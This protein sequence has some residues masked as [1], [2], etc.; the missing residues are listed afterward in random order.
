[1]TETIQRSFTAGEIS[2]ALGAR[3][4]LNKYQTGLDTL[5][6]AFVHAEGGV[7]NRAG[8]HYS[9]Y[10]P[11]NAAD[12]KLIPFQFNTEQTYM[13]VFVD[14]KMMVIMD[15]GFVLN[16]GQAIVSITTATECVVEITGHGYSNGDEVYF[17][18][19]T[20]AGDLN[21]NRYIVSDATAN[22]FKIKWPQDS[23]YVNS[24]LFGG[25]VSGGTGA[26]L[27]TLDHTYT[28][29]QLEFV[30]FTQSADVMT[31]VHPDHDPAELSRLDHNNWTLTDV[32]YSTQQVA[33]A[34]LTSVTL[35]GSDPATDTKVYAYAVTAVSEGGQESL[36]SPTS[37]T[38]DALVLGVARGYR[39]V[40][41]AT[42]GA[43]S[44]NIYK[45]ESESSD[46]FGYIG[47]TKPASVGL[48]A[49]FEDYNIAPDISDGPPIEKLPFDGADNK[50]STVN[51]YQQRIIFGSSNN[52]PEEVYMSRIG[53]YHSMRVAI[54]VKA[55]DAIQFTIAS[56]QVNEIR[57]IV[58]VGALLVLTS[59][60]EYKISEGQ[61]QVLAPTTVSA[62]PQSYYGSSHVQP[63]VV[64]HTALFIQESGSR[65]RDIGYTFESDSYSGS[66][67]SIMAQHLFKGYEVTDMTFSQEPYRMVWMTRDDGKMLGLTYHRE[68]KI[69]GWSQ[70][71]T[72]GLFKSVATIKEGQENILYAIIQRVINGNTVNFVERMRERNWQTAEDAY[73]LDAGKTIINAIPSVTVTGLYHL[74]GE[75][76]TALADGNVVHDLLVN[77][78]GAITLPNEATKVHVGFGYISDV[79][80]LN[81]DSAQRMVKGKEKSVGEAVFQFYESR[82]GYI[83]PDA[84]YLQEI[85][86][87]EQS[88]DYDS[89]A[90]R[91]YETRISM[92]S[93]WTDGGQV[94]FRQSDPLPFTILAISPDVAVG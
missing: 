35:F 12:G 16:T 53:D 37:A 60:G 50:P 54:P 27:F 94:L 31:L 46:V 19:L 92:D 7:S 88:D 43:A 38:A 87:R 72:N 25:Y 6:N 14:S 78:R 48:T 15:G 90:L 51:L 83:G 42:V 33:P 70:H 45:M 85:K 76:V 65:V 39:I 4:D 69:T 59:G 9:G 47:T 23:S 68:H 5:R 44:Y 30:K 73:C 84:T 74:A 21:G 20:G 2:P 56:Q 62:K 13:L 10:T 3:A 55:D 66:D 58:A 75:T 86:P 24:F 61:D 1:M 29:A 93:G 28:A 26:S 77:D 40:I 22:T 80:T 82:G 67:L 32:D 81:I 91:S 63:V 49:T 52:K 18:G 57:H 64:D 41:P 79:K 36:L 17:S 8:F 11:G 34:A 89:M 71:D